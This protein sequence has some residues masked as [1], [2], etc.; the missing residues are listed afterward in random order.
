MVV[1]KSNSEFLSKDDVKQGDILIFKDEGGYKQVDFSKT[2][3]GKDIKEIYQITVTLP[4][5]KDKTLTLNST[6]RTALKEGFG[7]DTQNWVGRKGMVN[8]VKQLCFG[9]MMDV[10]VITPVA[11][12]TPVKEDLDKEVKWD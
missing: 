12:S 10:L 2:K 8:L 11:D 5:G 1:L 7:N 3:D 9:K 4:N 6:S